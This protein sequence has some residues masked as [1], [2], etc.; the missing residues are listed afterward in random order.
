MEHEE[1]L[2]CG[3]LGLA[4]GAVHWRVWAPRAE[5]VELV[6]IAGD[7]RCRY[8]MTCEERGYFSYTAAHIAV[9]QRYAY[10]LDGGPERPDPV[11]RWQPDGV[12]RASAVLRPAHFTWADQAWTGVQ[13]ADLVFYELHVGT[14]TPEGTFEAVI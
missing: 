11:S 4:D 10:R 2:R 12:H 6:L 1:M 9:G 13:R 5:R 7:E 3:A 14:F 8:T